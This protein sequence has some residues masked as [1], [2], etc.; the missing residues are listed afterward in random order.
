MFIYLGLIVA[1]LLLL[2]I[3]F[4]FGEIFDFLDFDFGGDGGTSTVIAIGITAFGAGGLLATSA[5]L[6]IVLSVLVA[7]G[8][9]VALGA[10]SAWLLT[11]FHKGASGTDDSFSR[12][13]GRIGQV[14][15]SISADSPGEVLLSSADS[16]SQRIA[17]SSDG[18]SIRSGS[19][20]RVVEVVGN[21]LI[22]EP[23]LPSTATDEQPEKD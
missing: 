9:A 10:L 22:V 21:T 16:T 20:V 3:A 1:G 14:M 23:V 15:T 19:T 18:R 7:A 5:G 2:L 12:S 13:K 8:S 11:L 17:R 4:I 6:G